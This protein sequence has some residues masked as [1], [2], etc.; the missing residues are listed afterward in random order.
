[1]PCRARR[2]GKVPTTDPASL[3]LSRAQR[4]HIRY[5]EVI[6]AIR[7]LP[8]SGQSQAPQPPVLGRTRLRAQPATVAPYF[9][10]PSEVRL[11]PRALS[12]VPQ[13]IGQSRDVGRNPARLV[14][15]E[16]LPPAS[17]LRLMREHRPRRRSARWHHAQRVRLG[18]DRVAM[19]QEIGA[20]A[21]SWE[22]EKNC[23]RNC[24]RTAYD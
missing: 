22:S 18:C 11:L 17:L 23:H 7:M 5:L 9:L 14:H 20:M 24:H 21:R 10:L 13:E 12:F 4:S 2:P 16:H 6:H 15:R 3:R 19:G 1:V 8:R